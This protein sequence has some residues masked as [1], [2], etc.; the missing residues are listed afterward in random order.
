MC[1]VVHNMTTTRLG[2]YTAL[3]CLAESW[4]EDKLA[5]FSESTCWSSFPYF[6]WVLS[7]ALEWPSINTKAAEQKNWP[8]SQCCLK[9]K[10]NRYHLQFAQNKTSASFVLSTSQHG[11]MGEVF[12]SFLC[13]KLSNYLK[14]VLSFKRTIA[15]SPS[16]FW[17]H[18]SDEFCIAVL[19]M[20]TDQSR[21]VKSR[22]IAL[23]N[24]P[25]IPWHTVLLCSVQAGSPTEAEISKN[26]L[27][28]CSFS[29]LFLSRDHF[30]PCRWKKKKKKKT[31]LSKKSILLWMLQDIA[32]KTCI[33]SHYRKATEREKRPDHCVYHQHSYIHIPW[34]TPLNKKALGYSLYIQQ[35]M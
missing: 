20:F 31:K 27:S 8:A 35:H 34:D 17:Q 33:K 19:V 32:M 21:S 11:Q 2:G 25:G 23:H 5:A 10:A 12:F 24:S 6:T 9:C 1:S 3:G 28:L 30:L 13:W 16:V 29:F 4:S 15:L 18:Y 14:P 26:K 22:I 7:W